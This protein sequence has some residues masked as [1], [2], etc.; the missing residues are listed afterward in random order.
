MRDFDSE[1]PKSIK[2]CIDAGVEDV[3]VDRAEVMF[4]SKRIF[5]C[6]PP[7]LMA[8]WGFHFPDLKLKQCR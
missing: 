5:V 4:V 8:Q 7:R 6:V 2:L 3:H 1:P